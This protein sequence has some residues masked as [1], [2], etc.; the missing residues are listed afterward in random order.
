METG[1]HALASGPRD[2]ESP[3]ACGSAYR[4]E[5]RVTP[6]TRVECETWTA[7]SSSACQLGDLIAC[8]ARR[9]GTIRPAGGVA[10]RADQSSRAIISPG[11]SREV[12][13]CRTR[14]AG[15]RRTAPRTTQRRPIRL[16]TWRFP[17]INHD[18]RLPGHPD[19]A[20][21]SRCQR[22]RE[23]TKH[24]RHPEREPNPDGGPTYPGRRSMPASRLR[25]TRHIR[26]PAVQFR[27]GRTIAVVVDR[28]RLDLH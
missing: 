23:P 13:A 27:W 20:L 4:Y 26:A 21:I 14:P 3:C 17:F 2:I 15:C 22:R 12:P 1:G 16:A 11:W 24:G 6:A 5:S 8:N 25:R 7:T 18:S 19:R 10:R 9:R 28:G